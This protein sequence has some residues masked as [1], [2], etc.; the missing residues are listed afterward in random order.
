M[1]QSGKSRRFDIGVSAFAMLGAMSWSGVAFAQASATIQGRVEGA[2]PGTVVTLTDTVTDQRSTAKVD[3]EG[4]YIV[5]G[6][7]PSRYHIEAP[8]RAAQDVTLPVGETLTIDFASGAAAGA[9]EIVVTARRTEVHTATVGTNVSQ[10]QIENLPQNDRNFLNFAALAP[11][12]A[13]SANPNS[14]QIQAGA[15]SSDNVNVFIDGQ[16]F[17]NQTGHGGVVGQNFSQG[18]PYPQSAIQE[19][20]VETQNFNAAFEQAGSAIINAVTRTGGDEFHGGAFVQYVPQ[21]WYGQPFYSRGTPKPDYERKQYGFNLG[22]PIIEDKLHFFVAFEGTQQTNPSTAVDFGT[23]GT[24]TPTVAALIAANEGTYPAEFQQDLF[25]G[26]L[27]WFATS[28]DTVDFSIYDRS[29]DDQR[30]FGFRA[31]P[32]HGRQLQNELRQYQLDWQHRGDNWLNSLSIA[33]QDQTTGTPNVTPGPEI[34]LTNGITGDTVAELG[35]HFFQQ[36]N[37]QEVLTF[38]DTLTFYRDEHVFR[39]GVK[40][41]TNSYTRFENWFTNGSYRYDAN[42][43]NGVSTSIPHTAT[44]SRRP[45][46]PSTDDNLQVGLFVQ[47]DWTV[48]EHWTVNLGLRWDY[49]SNMFNNDYVTPTAI[50]TALRAYPGWQAAG[51]NPEDYI[52]DGNDREAYMGAF[53]PRIGVSYDVS[54]DRD[55]VFFAGAGRYYDRNLYG[56]SQ[57]ERQ[58]NDVRSDI[59]LV[60]DDNNPMTTD[61]VWSPAYADPVALRAFAQSN[62]LSGGNVWL[63]NDDTPVPYT[64]A[65][66]IGV[67]KQFGDVQ[68]SLTLAHNYSKNIF[69]YVRGNRL[70]DGTFTPLGDRWIV[71]NFPAAGQLAGFSGKLNIGESRGEAEYNALYLVVDKPF[72][73]ESRYGYTAALTIQDAT[74]NIATEI[75]ADEFF[76]GPHVD[77]FGWQNVQGVDK[78]RF[79]GTGIVELPWEIMLSGT[80]TLA[81]GP[82]FG[83]INFVSDAEK[84]FPEACCI[85]NLGGAHFP[86][87][88]IAFQNVDAR[89]ARTFRLWRG[90]EFTAELGVFNVFDSVNRTYSPWAGG[91]E[92]NTTGNA[93]TVQV[94]LKYA[95]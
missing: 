56:T 59:R 93:R 45:S 44:I 42:T 83:Q 87:D 39:A 11:G 23:P 76:E 90:N 38:K 64:D 47:D 89:I 30:D 13:V 50:A 37:G 25:F 95:F 2:A 9:D 28:A 77:I 22:G 8:G 67:R 73:K 66:N 49:E 46:T 69:Q 86:D 85:A 5:G 68:V 7:R 19:F 61:L 75:G 92:N 94:G 52:T 16:S 34:V 10:F 91:A 31:A 63:L 62:P 24:I 33:Y 6:L 88:D 58:I 17:K 29:E 72:T 18:N 74:T 43:F 65:F 48:N 32:E 84:P 15:V 81:S 51:I 71:D 53:Q 12:V 57:I 55:L 79:V 54:G 4:D 36:E 14:R 82:A 40:V 70:P 1:R 78:W 80:L 27:T 20:R 21:E 41:A 60:F 35:G 3:A 26:K